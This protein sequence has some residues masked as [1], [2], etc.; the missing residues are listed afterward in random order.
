[1]SAP[2]ICRRVFLWPSLIAE[3][4]HNLKAEF[5]ALFMGREADE[6][7]ISNKIITQPEQRDGNVVSCYA[8]DYDYAVL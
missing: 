2:A 3:A 7:T 1:M 6:I 4:Y 5:E 8:G